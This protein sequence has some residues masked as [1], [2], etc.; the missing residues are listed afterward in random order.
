MAALQDISLAETPALM[1]PPGVTSNFVNPTSLGPVTN[2]LLGVSLALTAV[3]IALRM[4][5]KH[6][7]NGRYEWEDCGWPQSPQQKSI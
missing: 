5:T 2:A 4:V 7:V 3:F 6:L 1:P